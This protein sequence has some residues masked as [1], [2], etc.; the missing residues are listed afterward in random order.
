MSKTAWII[1][2]GSGIGAAVAQRLVSHEG[3]TVAISGRRLEKL[4]E[5]ASG[6]PGIRPHLLDVTDVDAARTC[7]AGVLADLGRIDLMLYGAVAPVR[8]PVGQY[9]LDDFHAAFEANYFGFVHLANALIE[10]MAAQDGG[11]IAVIG[12]LAGYYGLPT[13]AA[14]SSSKAA[15]MAL[16]QTMHTELAPRGIDVR[17][18]S[19][20]YVRSELTA[21]NRRPMPFL[22]DAEE[23]AKRIVD[24]LLRSGRFEVAFP[25]RM[26][27]AM[28]VLR[29]LPYPVAFGLLR[30]GLPRGK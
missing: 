1:G 23:A 22:M 30:N 16:A 26:A 20:G 28:R 18:V 14:Y 6:M 9:S 17:L 10:P 11:Q 27:M 13:S 7:L 24:G 15:I 4:E 25:W 8:M 21:R 2:G 5:V 3:F 19:P 29:L 12:S